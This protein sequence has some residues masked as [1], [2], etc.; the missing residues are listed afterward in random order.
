MLEKIF[1]MWEGIRMGELIFGE[2]RLLFFLITFIPYWS[3]IIIFCQSIRAIKLARTAFYD[4]SWLAAQAKAEAMMLLTTDN[5]LSEYS[6]Y[7]SQSISP[8]DAYISLAG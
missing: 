7:Q 8:R 5:I 1:Q 4:K 2:P 6:C 3:T